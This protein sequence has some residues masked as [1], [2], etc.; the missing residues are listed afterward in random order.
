MNA[1]KYL[2][3]QCEKRTLSDDLKAS[4]GGLQ[5]QI[6]ASHLRQVIEAVQYLHAQQVSDKKI[7]VLIAHSLSDD[8]LTNRSRS[9]N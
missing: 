4:V 1:K 3:F 2:V 6:I 9:V 8:S 7:P 5:E